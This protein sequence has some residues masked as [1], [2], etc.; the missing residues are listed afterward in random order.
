MPMQTIKTYGPTLRT[1][2][3]HRVLPENM[4]SLKGLVLV[5]HGIEGHGARYDYFGEYLAKNN[6]ATFAIDHIAHGMSALD[7]KQLGDWYPKDFEKNAMN[8]YFL[9]IEL[10]RKFPNKPL[11][12]LGN[13]FGAYFAQYM[14]DRFPDSFVPDGVILSG[15]GLNNP[16]QYWLLFQ[17]LFKKKVFHDRFQS[18]QIFK[19]RIAYYNRPFKPNRTTY[20]WLTSDEDE[21]DKFIIDPKSGFVGTIGYYH[22]YYSNII[23]IPE[24]THFRYTPRTIPMLIMGGGQDVVTRK[25]RDIRRIYDFY[26]KKGFEDVTLK[27]YEQDRHDIF[28]ERNKD[29]VLGDVVDWLNLESGYIVER[30]SENEYIIKN[31]IENKI[32]TKATPDSMNEEVD[33]H[34]VDEVKL[35]ENPYLLHNDIREE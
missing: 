2:Y 28:F 31:E 20:D 7:D 22:E 33:N 8:C 6:Y 1:F 4:E 26:K 9:A 13:D 15:V 27:I 34:P 30:T 18:N 5:F 12:I 32:K 21:V 35:V 16:R 24:F 19:N 17:S 3:Y 25:A 14:M 11:F 29:E 23:K 10:K